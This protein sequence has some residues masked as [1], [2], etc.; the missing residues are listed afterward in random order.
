MV[1]EII[2]NILRKMEMYHLE[3]HE[4]IPIYERTDLVDEPHEKFKIRTA[5]EIVKKAK[6]RNIIH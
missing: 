2:H 6:M 5:Y 1:E 3:E 4:Y